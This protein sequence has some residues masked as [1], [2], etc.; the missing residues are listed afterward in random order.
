MGLEM[1]VYRDPR[2]FEAKPMF[3]RTWR[4]LGALAAGIPVCTAVFAA[5]TW[6]AMQLGQ[7]LGGATNIAMV[8]IVV[9]FIPFGAWG[10]WRPK[11]LLPEL[12]VPYLIRYYLRPRELLYGQPSKSVVER[13]PARERQPRSGNAHAGDAAE[14]GPAYASRSGVGPGAGRPGRSRR[15]PQRPTEF[16][17][18]P[19]GSAG[20]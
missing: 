11:E 3:G 10:W 19:Q 1:K 8:V 4:Q 14:G 16:A 15:G 13:R 5:V 9:V 6:G 18:R 17:A 12:Y 20:R 7:D 2:S